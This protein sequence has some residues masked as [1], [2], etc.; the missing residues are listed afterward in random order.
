ME[1]YKIAKDNPSCVKTPYT[2]RQAKRKLLKCILGRRF[3]M[4]FLVHSEVGKEMDV[5]FPC[6]GQ[7]V[8]VEDFQE[9]DDLKAQS[10]VYV[11]IDNIL[12]GCIYYEDGIREDARHVVDTLSRQ[13][14]NTYMLSGD[15]R[16]N[17]EYIA[18][19]VGIPKE[20]CV[21]LHMF[22]SIMLYR[23]IG[24][25]YS[26]FIITIELHSCRRFHSN[27]EV[28][29]HKVLKSHY[30]TWKEG[31]QIHVE[32]VEACRTL[33]IAGFHLEWLL[34]AVW[35]LLSRSK[36]K[37]FQT[38]GEVDRVASDIEVKSYKIQDSFYCVWFERGYFHIED[39]DFRKILKVSKLQL[40]WKD[41]FKAIG[42]YFEGLEEIGLDILNLID[43][44]KARIQVWISLTLLIVLKPEFRLNAV[45]LVEEIL[46]DLSSVDRSLN[47]QQ[48]LMKA[49]QLWQISYI[50]YSLN[51]AFEEHHAAAFLLEV[52]TM[53]NRSLF[54]RG[55][56]VGYA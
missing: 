44:S 43:C 7:G 11:G 54:Y 18:S 48:V 10:V 33:S 16:S 42:E 8:T 20:K 24:Y 46:L 15:K 32:D 3:D 52:S 30:C 9:T 5:G 17:A 47:L 25:A 26:R 27:M 29:S 23:I 56:Y 39:V 22:R 40:E 36:D 13:G 19:L 55:K 4:H 51:S 28:V 34:Q 14:I 37:F 6:G 35:E 50:E 41:V 53:S 21:N 1:Q 12:A 2:K 45:V 49:F 38:L 31:N